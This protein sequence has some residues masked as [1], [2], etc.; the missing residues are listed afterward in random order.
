MATTTMTHTLEPWKKVSALTPRGT[1]ITNIF[2]G[3]ITIAEFKGDNG[4]A[5]ALRIVA[6]VNACKGVSN[7]WLQENGVKA[8]IEEIQ[9]LKRRI[10]DLEE[11]LIKLTNNH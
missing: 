6:C 10:A 11:Q 2:T 1:T 3:E 7:E 8:S 4:K 9:F 5:N